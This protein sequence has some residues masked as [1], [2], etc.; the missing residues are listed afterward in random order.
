MLVRPD[1]EIA[2]WKEPI[3][4]ACEDALLQGKREV[5]EGNVAAENEIEARR[6]GLELQILMNEL[7]AV[8]MGGVDAEQRSDAVESLLEK[9]TRQF[10]QARFLIAGRQRARSMIRSASAAV[11]E[12]KTPGYERA[13]SRSHRIFRV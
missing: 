4:E 7:N 2:M 3:E 6:R 9:L 12:R 1:D 10:T 13:N 8:P 11:T 5:G